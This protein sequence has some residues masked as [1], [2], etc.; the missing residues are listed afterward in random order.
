MKFEKTG[1]FVANLHH[2]TEYVIHI[3]HVVLN[4]ICHTNLNRH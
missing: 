3:I 1:K 4:V 2:K